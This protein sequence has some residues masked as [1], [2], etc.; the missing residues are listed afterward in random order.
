MPDNAIFSIK[1][2]LTGNSFPAGLTHGEIAIN[3][4][5]NKLYVGGQTAI[6]SNCVDSVEFV[7]TF[8]Q[9]N[10]LTREHFDIMVP[11]FKAEGIKIAFNMT[12]LNVAGFS[13]STPTFVEGTTATP[14]TFRYYLEY[15]LGDGVEGWRKMAKESGYADYIGLS[16]YLMMLDTEPYLVGFADLNH[17]NTDQTAINALE[18]ANQ[19]HRIM[20]EVSPT[21]IITEYSFPNLPS[22][23]ASVPGDSADWIRK[24]AILPQAN[25]ENEKFRLMQLYKSRLSSPIAPSGAYMDYIDWGN[26]SAYPYDYESTVLSPSNSYLPNVYSSVNKY[27]STTSL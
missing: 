13:T 4:Y 19:A 18:Y 14:N 2:A 25:Y 22:Y 20:K 10:R 7:A 16:P 6:S 11:S 3:T 24:P 15:F 12:N 27:T 23:F 8:P 5:D 1:K 21:S 26:F 9:V 17:P